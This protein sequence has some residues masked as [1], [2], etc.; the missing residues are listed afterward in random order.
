MRHTTASAEL[1]RL[2]S[3]H[4]TLETELHMLNRR[5]HLTPAEQQRARIIK[6]QKLKAKDRIR[7][8]T[9]RMSIE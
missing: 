5:A 3:A 4:Q 7:V 1:N 8:L 9:S 6:K 2:K